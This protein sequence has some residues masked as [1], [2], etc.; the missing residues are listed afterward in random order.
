M[1]D[2]TGGTAEFDHKQIHGFVRKELALLN[3]PE[4]LHPPEQPPR[5]E[6]G[7]SD[8]PKASQ[9]PRIPTE[10]SSISDLQQDLCG[11]ALSGGGI[12]SATFNLGLMQALHQMGL[13]QVFD[14]VATVSGGGYI[15][16]FWSAWRRH[17]E[18]LFP[19]DQGG[20]LGADLP[21]VRHLREFSH[22]LVPRLGLFSFDT[23][24][25]LA[26]LLMALVP[27]LLVTFSFV[28][29]LISAWAGLA[30]CLLAG[31][32]APNVKWSI[33][34]QPHLSWSVMTLLT[35]VVLSVGMG[36]K[37]FRRSSLFTLLATAITAAIWWGLNPEGGDF[38]NIWPPTYVIKPFPTLKLPLPSFQ[39]SVFIYAP[40]LAWLGSAGLLVVLRWLASR[41][42]LVDETATVGRVVSLLLF[43]AVGWAVFTSFFLLGAL[44]WSESIPLFR[45][46]IGIAV[47][48]SIGYFVRLQ[49][50]ASR[51]TSKPVEPGR[52]SRLKQLVP[53]LLAYGL[54]VLMFVSAADL[55]LYA[56]SHHALEWVLWPAAAITLVSLFLFDANNTGLHAFYRSR[57]ARAYLGAAHGQRDTETE[58]QKNDDCELNELLTATNG[59][60]HPLGAPLHLICC[61]A[62]DLSSDPLA[63][64]YRGA[65]SAV[66]SPLGFSVGSQW[67]TW[68][69]VDKGDVPT[70]ASAVTASGAALNSHMGSLSMKLG[71]AVTFLMTA[72]NL[73]LGMWWPHPS[74]MLANK[75]GARALV[76][77]P[78]YKELL[79][80]S[81]VQE[82]KD[83][84]LSDG[85]HFENLALYE[86]VRRHCRY[87]VVSDCG[88]DADTAFDD[89]ANA[90]RR[91][92]EDFG[93]EIRIDLSPLRPGPDGLARQPMVA[94][95]IE[96][97]SGD[98]GVLLLVKPTLVGHEP[99][100]IAQYKRRNQAFPHESTGDQ[101]YDEAQWESYR[102]LGEHIA[103]SAF[104]PILEEEG[105]GRV[106]R[107]PEA[108]HIFAHARHEWQPSPAGYEQRFSDYAQHTSELDKLVCTSTQRLFSEVFKELEAMKALKPQGNGSMRLPLSFLNGRESGAPSHQELVDSLHLVRRAILFM[109]EVFFSE[110][111][112]NNHNHPIYL[113]VMNYIGRWALAPSFRMW[114]PLLRGLYPLRFTRFM[115]THF[116]LSR[117]LEGAEALRLQRDTSGYA[118]QCWLQENPDRQ[119]D[120]AGPC[121]SYYRTL[122]Y[123]ERGYPAQVALLHARRQDLP[124]RRGVQLPLLMWNS[125]DFYVPPGLWGVNFGEQFLNALV[126]GTNPWMDAELQRVLDPVAALVVEI[127]VDRGASVDDRK[128]WANTMQLYRGSGFTQPDA[129][130]FKALKEYKRQEAFPRDSR[131]ED[132]RRS[133]WLVREFS[134]QP[135]DLVV[136]QVES[137]LITLQ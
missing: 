62:N 115:E 81:R 67:V 18:G 85:G 5:A 96:Y 34:L 98:M 90:V 80:K 3:K 105:T 136:M 39:S 50:V 119:K 94:G 44:K 137:T 63:N 4:D 104:Q 97:P 129:E 82:G 60:T 42:R 33:L 37:Q 48:A 25:M 79:G 6:R 59:G 111:L 71:P 45:W 21:E 19:A 8:G 47:P 110:D 13:L 95:D 38:R 2:T 113:G 72:F 61:A 92:R 65:R 125:S 120:E 30:W 107:T 57:I 76:G 128:R 103:R 27:S 46:V 41:W 101:S 55:L 54:L 31:P 127:G 35:L 84:L 23:S 49:H 74:K 89:F 132:S 106:L 102:R 130:L 20:A 29:L 56:R 10:N 91:V 58:Q 135:S 1:D 32:G 112:A 64:L 24:R 12:R 124:I 52:R 15:G 69:E 51:Q 16:G 77:L 70:L 73:R 116:S 26:S 100:D 14:Y 118:I 123:G 75:Q 7:I 66:L 68:S 88:M 133:R 134:L 53:Q 9:A 17:H 40:C 108:I 43:L 99:S 93:V 83:V 28:V 86:L 11:L 78:F 114:W 22:F 87:I 122:S 36:R 126:S 109:Q 117:A 131:E 121:I